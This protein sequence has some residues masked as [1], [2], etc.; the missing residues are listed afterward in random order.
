MTGTKMMMQPGDLEKIPKLSLE[1]I[2][3]MD[4]HKP[5]DGLVICTMIEVLSL[6]CALYPEETME[7]A[8][9]SIR[10]RTLDVRTAQLETHKTGESLQ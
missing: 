6:M 1:V 8:I 7:T 2:N 3:A 4:V 9:E 10:S 5:S